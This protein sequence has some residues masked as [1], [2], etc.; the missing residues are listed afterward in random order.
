VSGLGELSRPAT[1]LIEKVSDAI[2]GVFKPYQ[3]VR[4]AKAEAEADKVRAK[5]EIDVTDLQ[6]RAFHRF[7][8]EEAKKQANIEDIT[9]KALPHLSNEAKPE[10]IE[11][12]WLSH[13]FDKSRLISD[14]AMQDIWS[15]VL[16][17]EANVPGSFSKR[18][19]NFLSSLDKTDAELFTALRKFCC[20]IE[21]DLVPLVFDALDPL[22]HRAGIG[23]TTLL[24]LE[25]IGLIQ[26]NS[27]RGFARAKLSKKVVLA[28]FDTEME[29]A[30]PKDTDNDLEV[31]QV[32]LTQIGV[33][34]VQLV[35]IEPDNQFM[36]Y[37]RGRLTAFSPTI[38]PPQAS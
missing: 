5:A 16:A 10:A 4:V 18:T 2:G 27:D 37:L 3:I 20:V 19:I 35:Q 7:L 34:L 23:F 14:E 11:K 32:L 17:G 26:F 6:R 1:V 36:E 31:G 12:D 8:E 15:K 24:H 33:E 38:R 9:R 22:Y 29:L 21:G 28:Y 30:M 25:S 13:F